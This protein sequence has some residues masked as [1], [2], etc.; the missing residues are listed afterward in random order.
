WL[1]EDLG[2][3]VVFPVLPLHGVRG[4]GLPQHAAFPGEDVMDNV[5]GIAQS[6]WD[7]RRL[8]RW[9]ASQSDQPVGVT[10]V[11]LGGFVTALVAGLGYKGGHV[12]FARNKAVGRFV[13]HALNS[14]GLS[15]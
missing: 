5:H 8:V 9:A 14:S 6:V 15:R 2:L 11:S 12:A 3:N 7:V 13:R 1:H 4:D 10:G